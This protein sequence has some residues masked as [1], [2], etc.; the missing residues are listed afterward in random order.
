VAVAVLAVEFSQGD[1]DCALADVLERFCGELLALTTPVLPPHFFLAIVH[2]CISDGESCRPSPGVLFITLSCCCAVNKAMLIQSPHLI[3]LLMSALLLDPEHM[4]QS[5]EPDVKEAIQC[6]A[7]DCFLQIALYEPGRALLENDEAVLEALRALADQAWSEDAK[8]SATRALMALGKDTHVLR[9]SDLQ[10]ADSPPHIMASYNWDHQ[11]VILRVVRSLQGRGYLVWVDTE[12]MKGATVDAMALAVEGCEL[13]LLGVSCAYKESGNCR[14]EAQYG[15]QKKKPF[16]PLKLTQGYEPDGWLG[17][18]LGTSLWYALYGETLDSES[19]FEDR[20]SALCREIGSRGRADAVTKLSEPSPALGP[21]MRLKTSTST[22]SDPPG[23]VRPA[24]TWTQAALSTPLPN[25]NFRS[26]VQSQS[27][28]QGQLDNLASP[29]LHSS[30][31]I[32]RSPS[33]VSVDTSAALEISMA[34]LEDAKQARADVKEMAMQ[35]SA[36]TR[37]VAKQASANAKYM[38]KQASADAKEM[39]KQ[40]SAD[41]KEMAKQAS[42]DVKEMARMML[43]R[44]GKNLVK[45]ELPAWGLKIKLPAWSLQQWLTRLVALAVILRWRAVF[46][47]AGRVWRSLGGT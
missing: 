47:L 5:Q 19:A 3:P 38:A 36:D 23:S 17:L 44:D 16:I 2:L 30:T 21:D 29:T 39:A 24:P 32:D 14:M 4:R 1:I 22:V 45:I 34:A 40:A 12:Q 43:E 8:L 35:T 28:M 18:L 20:I 25:R 27:L 11:D 15:L 41:A 46:G 42:A 7:C 26:S 13:M 10:A 37:E 6:G 9:E 33:S 31:M